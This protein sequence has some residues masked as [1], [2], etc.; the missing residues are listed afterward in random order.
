MVPT[1]LLAAVQLK[2][3]LKSLNSKKIIMILGMMYNKDHKEFISILKNSVHLYYCFRY[4]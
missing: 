4:T 3:Y 1:I 2:K